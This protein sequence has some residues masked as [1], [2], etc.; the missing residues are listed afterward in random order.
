MAARRQRSFTSLRDLLA[1]VELQPKEV[2]HLIQ[3]GGLDGLGDSRA[4]LLAEFSEMGH[5]GGALQ[6]ALPLDQPAVRAETMAQRLAWERFILGLPVSVTPL[7][8]VA[9]IP[10]EAL[11]LARLSGLTG[12]HIAVAGYRLPGWTG[13]AGFYLADGQTFVMARGHKSLKNP[14]V[15]QPVMARGHWQTD[16][17]GTGWLQVDTLTKLEEELVL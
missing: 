17:F 8:I 4:A 16:A 6:L 14:P 3:C 5:G 7:D 1:R 13:G 9:A 15:W 2:A 12:Q 11:P 10:S